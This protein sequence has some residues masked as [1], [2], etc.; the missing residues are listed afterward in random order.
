MVGEGDGGGWGDDEWRS[1]VPEVRRGSE[2]GRGVV[3]RPW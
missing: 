3:Y 2:G 1:A